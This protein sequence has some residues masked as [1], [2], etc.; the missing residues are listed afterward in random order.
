MIPKISLAAAFVLMMAP[1]MACASNRDVASRAP[2]TYQSNQSLP[3]VV[4]AQDGQ[5]SPSMGTTDS[6]NDNSSDNDNDSSDSA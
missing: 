3:K 6:D 1:P 2:I 5:D 4:V